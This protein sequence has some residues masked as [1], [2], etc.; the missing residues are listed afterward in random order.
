MP[1]TRKEGQSGKEAGKQ[2][3]TRPVSLPVAT[4]R[5]QRSANPRTGESG[6][7]TEEVSRWLCGESGFAHAR[8][9]H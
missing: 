9:A 1:I 5:P 7:G 8:H 3:S 6:E 4:G 2:A